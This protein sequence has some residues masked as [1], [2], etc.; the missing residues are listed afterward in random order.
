MLEKKELWNFNFFF[1]FLLTAPCSLVEIYRHLEGSCMQ[2]SAVMVI[3]VIVMKRVK[4]K[5]EK[6]L[7]KG[8]LLWRGGLAC[9]SCIHPS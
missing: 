4:I 2:P 7:I 9:D 6:K 3:A 1:I 8:G 5:T